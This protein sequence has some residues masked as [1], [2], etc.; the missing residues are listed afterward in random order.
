MKAE[1]TFIECIKYHKISLDENTD[2]TSKNT[3]PAD[4]S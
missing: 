4:Q 1:N 2:W 3:E